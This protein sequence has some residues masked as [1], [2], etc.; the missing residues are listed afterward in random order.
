MIRELMQLGM[1]APP[2]G[3]A[4]ARRR[5]PG[6]RASSARG[7]D[8]LVFVDNA[9]SGINAVLRSFALE[10]GDEILA[11]RPRLRRR[12][13]RR[14]VHRP[15]ARGD[16][17]DRRAAVS[18]AR[19][20]RLRR[21]RVDRRDHAA[22]PARG[23]RPRELG[24]R[25]RPAAGGDG[26]GLPRA[27]RRRCWS[28]ARMRRARST[29]DIPRLGVDWYA[30]NLHKWCVRAAQLR[31][32]LG[33]ARAAGRDCIPACI[34]WGITSGDWLQEFDWTGTRDPS[35]WLAAPAGARLHARRPRRR[36]RCAGTTMTLAW[37]SARAL[38]ARA[39]AARPGPRPSRWSAAWS[40]S[41]LPGAARAGQ[42]R[43][44][45]APARRAVLRAIASR[46]R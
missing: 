2:A 41:P 34:S 42:R 23:A 21:A 35:P 4:A 6:G 30:A 17:R 31:H 39:L 45:P 26:R 32:P 7:R 37:R 36:R 1:S 44:R 5:R 22:H 12:R 19:P 18:A 40:R 28:T 16:G 33:G 8:D 11:H 46:C 25:A 15:A 24:D 10:P 29:L 38:L 13:P 9:S 20:G 43:Q 27:R 3:A 14:G